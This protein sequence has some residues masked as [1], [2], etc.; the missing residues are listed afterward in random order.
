MKIDLYDKEVSWQRKIEINTVKFE[1][2]QK[3][4]DLI[5]VYGNLIMIY[6]LYREHYM[7]IKYNRLI[8]LNEHEV[9][10]DQK[11]TEIKKENKKI[12]DDFDEEYFLLDKNNK[13]SSSVNCFR[14]ETESIFSKLANLSAQLKE[15]K[16]HDEQNLYLTVSME[17]LLH[18]DILLKDGEGCLVEEKHITEILRSYCSKVSEINII[19]N[20]A[21]DIYEKIYSLFKS[22]SEQH[23]APIN[24][25]EERNGLSLRR[26][27]IKQLNMDVRRY[28]TTKYR[29]INDAIHS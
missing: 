21:K 3:N 7:R 25:K 26:D 13:E 27:I 17:M 14:K 2:N 11:Y 15:K 19:K 20:P 9:S 1:F 5:K 4:P 22:T 23:I 18:F 8:P 29:N 6:S 24:R 28:F 12:M 10:K 16:N